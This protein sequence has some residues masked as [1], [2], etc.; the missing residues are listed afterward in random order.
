M[1]LFKVTFDTKRFNVPNE[2][3]P[4]KFL[5]RTFNYGEGREG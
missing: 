5:T 4:M 3:A 2:T 1:D